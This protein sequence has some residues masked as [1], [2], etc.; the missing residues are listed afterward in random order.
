MNKERESKFPRPELGGR[1]EPDKVSEWYNKIIKE[2][3]LVDQ[4]PARGTIVLRPYGYA[5][6]KQVQK[7]LGSAIEDSDVQ[8]AYFPAIIPE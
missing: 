6:W 2:A 1:V 8:D 4:G 7:V 3:N 5:L